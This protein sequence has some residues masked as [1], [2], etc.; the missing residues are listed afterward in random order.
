VSHRA[1]PVRLAGLLVTA[2]FAAWLLS[3]GV[4]HAAPV[5][6]AA[7][8][9]KIGSAIATV[10]AAQSSLAS[11]GV[12]ADVAM[13]VEMLL[14]LGLEVTEGTRTIT[15]ADDA[16][17]HLL[18]GRL[19]SAGTSDARREAAD[20]LEN[21]L[22][23]MRSAAGAPA[24]KQP[25]DA[26]ALAAL[27]KDRPVTTDSAQNWLNQQLLK[28]LEAVSRWLSALFGSGSGA[29][30]GAVSRLLQYVVVLVPAIIVTWILVR[31]VRRRRCGASS[32]VQA[33]DE[34]TSAPAVAAAADLPED[35]LAYAR[36]LEGRGEHR[37]AVRVLYGGA[38][39][40]LVEAGVVARMRT[41]TNHEMLRDVRRSAPALAPSFENLTDEFERAWYGHADPG[42]DGFVSA[43]RVYQALL[44]DA[45]PAATMGTD[46]AG[47][48]AGGAA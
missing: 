35:P 29:D 32:D 6:A 47:E 43:S 22:V 40:H 46:A 8:R 37:E 27:L 34:A 30:A 48:H 19:R 7:F 13:D 2:V 12:A 31:A 24:G 9:A 26:G 28:I 16:T 20:R 21:H 36:L 1:A 39:R 18:T 3:A 33:P 41:R 11:A 38:A 15:V 25:W 44:S 10:T 45:P 23:S 5:S 42:A 4:A 17:V 14:P